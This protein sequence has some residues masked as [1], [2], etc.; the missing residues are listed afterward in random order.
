MSSS[1]AYT[2]FLTSASVYGL[3]KAYKNSDQS[4]ELNTSSNIETTLT[5]MISSFEQNIKENI[6]LHTSQL[7][8]L[9]ELFKLSHSCQCDIGSWF[10]DQRELEGIQQNNDS[11]ITTYIERLKFP[12]KLEKI[13][14]S[15]NP[16]YV[17]SLL[18]NYYDI[19]SSIYKSISS[20]SNINL[21]SIHNP[22]KIMS[23]VDCINY[24]IH[25][26]YNNDNQRIQFRL[27]IIPPQSKFSIVHRLLYVV[28]CFY[29]YTKYMCY[30]QRLIF[31]D[32]LSTCVKQS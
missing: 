20:N 26:R 23:Y 24:N 1:A 11:L 32:N 28:C 4:I 16:K 6:P 5:K 25:K 30:L 14:S 27:V 31:I 2:A 8:Q 9:I 15:F 21:S 22:S 3:V 13:H 19:H 10:I 17:S 18:A 7:N 29:M 12:Q